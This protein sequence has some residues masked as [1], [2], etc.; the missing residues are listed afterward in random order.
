MECSADI[1]SQMFGHGYGPEVIDRR[2][3]TVIS[4]TVRLNG[5]AGGSER[6]IMFIPKTPDPMW[7]WSQ[8]TKNIE[9]FQNMTKYD[10]F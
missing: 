8:T 6:F 10:L 9:L 5:D 3:I 1:A 4:M 7:C 2:L